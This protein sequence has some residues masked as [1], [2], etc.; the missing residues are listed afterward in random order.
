MW[1]THL[2]AH[3]AGVP[4]YTSYAS[5]DFFFPPYPSDSD[6]MGFDKTS[7]HDTIALRAGWY[8]DWS[9]DAN[10]AHPGGV[11]YARIIPLSIHDTGAFCGGRAAPATQA[12]QITAGFTG[13]ALIQNVQANPGALWLIGNEPDSIY[14]GNPIQAELYAELYHYFY[15]TIKTTD[16]TA[17]VAIGAI[18]QPSPLRMEYLD[19]VLNYY[20]NTYGSPFPTDLWNIHLYILNEGPCGVWGATVPPFS[21]SN[22]GWNIPWSPAALL[23][24]NAMRDNL[25][26]FRKWMYDRGYA[27]RPLI[28][29][30]FGVLPPPDF[31]GYE[32]PVAAQFLTGMFNML[33]TA[34]DP[35]V[36]YA[37]DGNR[38]V[39]LWAWF[40]SDHEPEPG[41]Q[42]YGGDLFETGGTSLTV[43]GQA[44]AAQA[45]AHHVPYVDLYPVPLITPAISPGSSGPATVSLAVQV[46]NRGTQMAQS[47]PVRFAQYDYF[48]GQLLSASVVT[49]SQVLTR[50]AGIQPQV[51]HEWSLAYG[52]M[53]TLTFEIDPAR[54]ISQAHRSNQ[55]LTYQVGWAFDLAITS[56]V[57]DLPT[58]FEWTGPATPTITAT[59]RNMGNLTSSAS[60]VEFSIANAVTGNLPLVY[61]VS[62][63]ALAPS[64][65][66]DVT[67]TLA[68][69]SPGT[70]IV[71]AAVQPTGMDL[72]TQNNAAT[73]NILA[74]L[75]RLYLPSVFRA[76][77]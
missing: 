47:V 8:V 63:P 20:R 42:K 45:N 17:Q 62:I 29:T 69:S 15:T 36:G 67:S 35:V 48:S 77:P 44:F 32:D 3:T 74:A 75:S 50:Y 68:I 6:R 55:Q 53:Y 24:I 9:A 39:Q 51:S 5:G 61:N 65:S 56:L 28:I 31:A 58:V 49:V 64:A 11:E 38:L 13:T 37:A 1:G 66:V 71:T 72:N 43:I 70:Y 73:L 16:P 22:S 7:S 46:D 25:R 10:P 12:S 30:E 23:N 14:L 26:A 19:K 4:A 54:T 59:V 41:Y 2:S 57:S 76:S 52:Y 18:V 27:D 21:S 34:T 60:D 40:S 33:L